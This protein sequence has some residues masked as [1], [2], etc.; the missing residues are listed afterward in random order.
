MADMGKFI[1]IRRH[2]VV[3]PAFWLRTVFTLGL[4]LL[5]WHNDYVA[6]TEHS[7]VQRKGVIARHE[8]TVPL[9]RVQDVTINQSLLGRLLG[10]G[11]IRIE[12]AGGAGTEIVTRR[13]DRPGSFRDAI[14]GQI[15]AMAPPEPTETA[16]V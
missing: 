13:S 14:F 2:T 5:W 8:R 6:L 1:A 16:G 3:H 12:T 9:H 7:I 4:Y 11:N 15:Q 10:Y